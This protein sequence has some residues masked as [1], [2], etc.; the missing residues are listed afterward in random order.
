MLAKS[1][2]LRETFWTNTNYNLRTFEQILNLA[3]MKN[4]L[5][6]F[7]CLFTLISFADFQD[8]FFAKT[9]RIDYYH[10]GDF[11]SEYYSIDEVKIEPYWSGSLKNLVVVCASAVV[12]HSPKSELYPLE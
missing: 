3:E 6:L 7:F 1:L 12:C 10:S 5:T 11:Q 2:K 9:L 8:T 4:L